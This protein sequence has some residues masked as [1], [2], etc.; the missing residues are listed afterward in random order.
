[1]YDATTDIDSP[2][3]SSNTL[4]LNT[5]SDLSELD[6]MIC[7]DNHISPVTSNAPAT[8]SDCTGVG[9]AIDS[10]NE[11]GDAVDSEDEVPD[12]EHHISDGNSNVDVSEGN[13]PYGCTVC[14]RTFIS[15][16]NPTSPVTLNV[17]AT[18]SDCI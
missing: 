18:P 9:D 3:S 17:P 15:R 16:G 1:M 4:L 6:H 5:S 14:T 11:V 2:T 7:H 13:K 12:T 10:E 8:P